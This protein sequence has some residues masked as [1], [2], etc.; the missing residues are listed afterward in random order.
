VNAALPPSIRSID[1][2]HVFVADRAAAERWYEQ[3]LGLTRVKDYEVWAAGGGPLTLHNREGTVH[4]A[5]FERPT[6]KCR[7]TIAFGVGAS[8]FLAW[9]THLTTA[10]EHAPTVEDHDLSVSLYFRDPDGNP[11]EITTYEYEAAKAG[12]QANDPFELERFLE[13]QA[14]S[15]A[16]AL[17]ELRAGRKRTHWS[18]FILPQIVGLG[19]SPMSVRF[20][21]RSLAEARAYLEHPVLGAR[22]R[23]CV[24]AMNSHTGLGASEVLG[25]IDAQKFRSCL[26]LFAHADSSEPVFGEALDKYFSGTPDAATLGILGALK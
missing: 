8:E 7:S 18:W 13:A 20:A 19:A 6:E 23:E 15:Y 24:A 26:T 12:L 16:Q 9:K 22:L 3:V 21:I 5:L 17:S 14:T 10:L 1:H 4:I 11:Y 25:E 2:I